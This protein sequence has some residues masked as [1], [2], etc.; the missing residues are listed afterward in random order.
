MN[1]PPGFSVPDSLEGPVSIRQPV[2][3]GE[4][5]VLGHVNHT[6]HLRWF[7]NA[8]FQWFERV[9]VAALTRETSSEIGPILARVTCEYRA[10][11]EFPDVIWARVAC[12][13]LGGSSLRLQTH[14]WSEAR[15]R[16]VAQGEAVVVLVDYASGRSSPIPE[17][18]RA[19][20][21]ASDGAGLS[22]RAR[23]GPQEPV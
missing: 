19:A 13:E 3:W 14:I 11:V 2:A 1:V 4:L 9:G 8:R 10:P 22:E 23:P 16:E 17:T 21:R 15:G 6:V 12:V 18:I 5:D 7:E 20:I